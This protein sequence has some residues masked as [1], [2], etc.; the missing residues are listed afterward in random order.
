MLVKSL[1]DSLAYLCKIL[2]VLLQHFHGEIKNQSEKLP[3]GIWMLK[4]G[5]LLNMGLHASDTTHIHTQQYQR[6]SHELKTQE[7]RAY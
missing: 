6:K 3:G 4:N 7:Q 1:G 5:G 2:P